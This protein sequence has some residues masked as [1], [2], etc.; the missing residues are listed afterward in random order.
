M[1]NVNMAMGGPVGGAPMPMMNNGAAPP[2]PIPRQMQA[3]EGNRAI[4][5]TYIYEYFLR[6]NMHDCA[7]S[8]LQASDGQIKIQKDSAGGRRDEN[9]NL[10]GNGLDD[11]MDTDSKDDLDGKRP[12]DLPAPDL[13]SSPLPDSCFL[14]EW[15]SLFWDMYHAQKGGGKAGPQ[16]QVT[17]YVNHT[18]VG[19]S[20]LQPACSLVALLT[21]ISAAIPATATRAASH[22]SPDAARPS[23]AV[24]AKYAKWH[25]Q[26]GHEEQPTANSYGQ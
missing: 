1:Q 23:V 4:L 25:G 19:L 7:R 13:P 26:H 6:H 22:A 11:S 15:F 14:L 5:N 17:Q 2:Q 24:L 3:N 12:D 10:I 21:L 16:P 8:L 20:R 9:G 18:Q